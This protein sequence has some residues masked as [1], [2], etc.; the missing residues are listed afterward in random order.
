MTPKIITV[1]ILKIEKK[2]KTSILPF[3]NAL[4][5]SAMADSA[6]LTLKAPL[7]TAVDNIYKYFF[8]VFQR[9]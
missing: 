2:K 1:M 7:T 9:K 3:Y 4:L 5:C 8:I 6:D